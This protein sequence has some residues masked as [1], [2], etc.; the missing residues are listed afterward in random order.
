VDA[1]PSAAWRGTAVHG[2]LE[3]WARED[4]CDPDRLLPRALTLL[5]DPATHPLLRALWQPR[6][7]AAFEWVAA[8]TIADRAAG[9]AVLAVE[10]RGTTDLA[11]IELTGRFDR[12]DRMPDGG[13]GIVDYKTGKA[14]S[15]AA[16]RGGFNLQL[17]LLGA[18]AEAGGFG[19][20]AGAATAFEYWS[21]A[22]KGDAFGAVSS[23]ADPAGKGG[24][25][26]TDDFVRAARDSFAE[27]AAR[28]LTGEEPF[29]AK[30]HPEFAPYAE[31]DQL[32]RR[33]EWYGRDA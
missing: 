17:G 23:P 1:D 6:L 15:V 11:G 14:P 32:M 25:I 27:A 30:L 9:R 10:G 20:V 22:K 33:D 26:V 18:I 5:A 4:A 31:Y 7:I 13:L 19:G 12:I 28:W 2:V 3:A 24:R 8:R 21:L 16:V 29:T